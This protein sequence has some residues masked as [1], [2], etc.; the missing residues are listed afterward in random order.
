MGHV[1][2]FATKKEASTAAWSALKKSHKKY[3]P[4]TSK[5]CVVSKKSSRKQTSKKKV[6]RRTSK[7]RIESKKK[8][9]G[10]Y[11]ITFHK[12]IQKFQCRIKRNGVSKHV[13]TF[14]TEKEAEKACKA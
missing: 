7:K 8:S 13:G 3:K 9:S 14:A 10:K 1:G 5:K 6:I 11:F 2:T 4:N 12:R